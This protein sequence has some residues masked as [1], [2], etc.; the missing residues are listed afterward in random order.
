SE[1][2][3]RP[4]YQIPTGIGKVHYEWAFHGR[5]RSSFGV[6]LHFELSNREANLEILSHIE[7]DIPLLE[8][9]LQEE[10]VIQKEWGRNWSRIYI[11]KD[12]GRFTPELKEWAVEK[13]GDHD[14]DTSATSGPPTMARAVAERLL[15]STASPEANTG[16]DRALTWVAS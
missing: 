4:W 11:T 5:P 3:G 12:E 14:K 15:P 9:A 1:P 13:D 10:V 2:G 8:Q 16:L 6:E 7:A